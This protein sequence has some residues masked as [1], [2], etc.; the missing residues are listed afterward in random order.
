MRGGGHLLSWRDLPLASRLELAPLC[1][2]QPRRP[3]V[4]VRS[5]TAQFW[6]QRE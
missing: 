1:P 6:A 4:R 3:S 2:P 5:L